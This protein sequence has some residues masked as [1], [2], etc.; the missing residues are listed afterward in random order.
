M[1]EKST[2]HFGVSPKGDAIKFFSFFMFFFA[3]I[4]MVLEIFGLKGNLN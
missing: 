3:C 2:S 4:E 1:N